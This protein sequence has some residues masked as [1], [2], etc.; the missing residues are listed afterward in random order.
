MN[1]RIANQVGINLNK[2]TWIAF[3]LQRVWAA[4]SNCT[5]SL[6]YFMIKGLYYLLYIGL[7]VEAITIFCT[8]INRDLFKASN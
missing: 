5:P 3:D 2:A 8:L 6:F 7:Y 4:N 1:N